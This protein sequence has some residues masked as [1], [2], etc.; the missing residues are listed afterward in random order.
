[1]SFKDSS[2]FAVQQTKT[3]NFWMMFICAFTSLL[4]LAWRSNLKDS[5]YQNISDRKYADKGYGSKR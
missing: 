4:M 3:T 1:M 2:K 5:M